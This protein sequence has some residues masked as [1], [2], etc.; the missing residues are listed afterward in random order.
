MQIKNYIY[1]GGKEK[2]LSFDKQFGENILSF[3]IW[4]FNNSNDLLQLL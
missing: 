4:G 3:F 2:A 1:N